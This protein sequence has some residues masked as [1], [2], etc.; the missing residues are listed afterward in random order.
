MKARALVSVLFLTLLLHP[1]SAD[2]VQGRDL[3]EEQLEG[4]F[5]NHTIEGNHAVAAKVRFSVPIPGTAYLLTVHGYP[6]NLAVCEQLIAP[7]NEDPNLSV[8][9]GNTYFCEVLR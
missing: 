6:D 2:S 7:Y 5:R 9:P 8:M 1:G 3:S 4:F